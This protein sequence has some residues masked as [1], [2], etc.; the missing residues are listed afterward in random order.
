MREINTP[1]LPSK[2]HRKD[3]GFCNSPRIFLEK[4]YKIDLPIYG[5]WGYSIEDCVV[6]DKYDASVDPSVPFKGVPFEY[7]FA[8]KRIYAEMI[9]FKDE[10]NWSSG[11]RWQLL[12][13]TLEAINGR[14]Y[15]VLNFEVTA[16]PDKDWDYLGNDWEKNNGFVGDPE[17]RKKHLEENVKRKFFYNTQ[18]W[19]DITSFHDAAGDGES[20][21]IAAYR[22]GQGQGQYPKES[23]S[24][25]LATFQPDPVEKILDELD[26][27][28]NK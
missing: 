20:G 5:G 26:I 4:A 24:F 8:E 28:E 7:L 1:K 10:K 2:W 9:N 23:D 15:D 13:Q 27:L 18:F 25:D 11:I 16:F 19:F 14:T 17:G 12:L 21:T 22:P 6:I 3:T